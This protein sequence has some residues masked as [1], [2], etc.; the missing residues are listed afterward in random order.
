MTYR[1]EVYNGDKIWLLMKITAVTS[2]FSDRDPYKYTR[3]SK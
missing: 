2:K 1:F 3:P